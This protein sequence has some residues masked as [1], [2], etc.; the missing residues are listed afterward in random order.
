M[1]SRKI[2]V[3][4]TIP[5]FSQEC[6]GMYAR[7]HDVIHTLQRMDD[8]PWDY[9][10]VP[11]RRYYGKPSPNIMF[12][13]GNAVFRLIN[14]LR[15]TRVASHEAD[16]IHIVQGDFP[17]SLLVPLV[18]KKNVPIVA[19]PNVIRVGISPERVT[20]I[21]GGFK[22]RFQEILVRLG[23]SIHQW[24]R[25]VFH[26]KSPF[27]A[28]FKRIL[29]FKGYYSL[30]LRLGS[31]D[32]RKLEIIPSGVRTD[33]FSPSGKRIKFPS[34]FN[35][36][37]VGDARRLYLKGFDIFLM[38]LSELRKREVKFGAYVLGRTNDKIEK[39]IEDSGL[40]KYVELIGTIPRAHLGMYY[41]GADVYVC[42]SRYEADSTTATEALT[43][44][45]PVIGTNIPGI[46]KTLAFKLG[47]AKDLTRKLIEIYKDGSTYKRKAQQA[48]HAW[49]IKAVIKKMDIIYHTL[50][51][52]TQ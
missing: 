50:I 8:P 2:K 44:G 3:V 18:T 17:Y 52:Q 34:N 15:N 30:G 36:L 33:I 51:E 42:P 19:G 47:D 16:I 5:M 21:R 49:S 32:Q 48:A 41:R 4:Y 38:A 24:N 22:N 31:M 28:Y 37:Y 39:M 13:D 14:Y 27:S 26:R 29:V 25:L 6:T 12:Q 45:T 10:I 1:M 46:P 43:C 23:L 35:I 20:H 40:G 11:L 9:T 7:F